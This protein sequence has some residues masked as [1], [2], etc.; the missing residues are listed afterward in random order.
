LQ[1]ENDP[2]KIRTW[3]YNHYDHPHHQLIQFTQR[4]SAQNTF[5]H[6]NKAEITELTQKICGGLPGSQEFLGA[7]QDATT[8]LW[9][10]LSSEEQ[11]KY[12]ELAKEWSNDRPPKHIQAKYVTPH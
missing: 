7:L 12:R 5:Y 9:K 1:R 8:Q 4:W 11:V 3:F 6:E 10:R 2:Q